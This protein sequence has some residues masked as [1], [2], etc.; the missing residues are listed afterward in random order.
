MASSS[1]QGPASIRIEPLTSEAD[2]PACATLADAAMKPDGLYEFRKRYSKNVYDNTVEKLT[3]ALRDD[4]GRFFMFKTVVSSSPKEDRVENPKDA[5]VTADTEA[6]REHETIV[7]FTMW[8]KGYLEVPKMDPF[9]PK[10]ETEESKPAVE[11]GVVNVP[12][13]EGVNVEDAARVPTTNTAMSPASGDGALRPGGK[14]KPYYPDP[15][16]ELFRKLGNAYVSFIRGKRHLYL[17]CL[18][19]HPSYQRQGLGQKLLEWGVEVA[20][21]ENIVSWLFARPA[22]IKLY[23][24]NGWKAVLTVDVDVPDED[25]EVAPV[26]AMLRLPSR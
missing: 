12:I 10:N 1:S 25:L 23:E 20:D 22:G 24:R 5:G 18:A 6:Q 11:T 16:A 9:A 7:G 21:R 3:D 2:I 14:P 4:R 26:V 8:R 17:H 15:D 13:S 19:I